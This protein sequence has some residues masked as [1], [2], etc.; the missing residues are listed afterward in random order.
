MGCSDDSTTSCDS[1]CGQYPS[2]PDC[3]ATGTDYP[4]NW[5]ITDY[6]ATSYT[7]SVGDTVT[8]SW[9]GGHNVFLH[10]TN[11]CDDA[12]ATEVSS[13]SPA[14][15]TFTE[16]GSF[17]FACQVGQHCGNGQILTFTVV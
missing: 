5:I 1:A 15:Y 8:F 3:P 9:S 4:I 14:I 16:A 17:T 12:G 7:A 11:A 13:S 10:P 2:F 6:T